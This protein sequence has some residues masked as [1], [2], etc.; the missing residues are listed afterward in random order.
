MASVCISDAWIGV[1][2]TDIADN[3]QVGVI[4]IKVF[5]KKQ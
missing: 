3:P 2:S 1:I 5:K 4:V